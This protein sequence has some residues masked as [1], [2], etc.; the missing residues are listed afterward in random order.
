MARAQPP[1]PAD[2][3]LLQ[4][5][6]RLRPERMA[7]MAAGFRQAC[8]HQGSRLRIGVS[9]LGHDPHHA[10]LGDRAGGPAVLELLL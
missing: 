1:L 8:G 5:A 4:Q 2:Q 3:P 9:R 10:V 7:G 6:D